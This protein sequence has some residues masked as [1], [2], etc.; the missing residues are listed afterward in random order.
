M[1]KKI[2]GFC[3]AFVL[4][5]IVL[6]S[7]GHLIGM[8]ISLLVPYFAVRQFVKTSSLFAKFLWSI[9]GL[10]GLCTLF[11]NLPALAGIVA[12]CILYYG[13]KKW[14]RKEQVEVR[15]SNDPFTNFEKQWEDLKR[16]YV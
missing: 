10:V 13:Y 9:V 3:L 14:K 6:A 5:M 7:L 1:I 8:G 2:L 4:V 16:N 11:G 12:A 15:N